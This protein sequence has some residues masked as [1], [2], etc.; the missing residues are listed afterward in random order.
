MHTLHS[1]PVVLA[2]GTRPEIIKMAPVALCLQRLGVPVRILHTGQHDEE[3]ALP[4][5][6]FFG[7][8]PAFVAQRLGRQER[9]RAYAADVTYLTAKEAGFDFL[10]DHTATE[11]G[12][13]VQ[14]AQG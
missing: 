12:D 3:M 11:P 2:M 13:L 6:R 10:R 1:A 9:R 8:T 4:L 5:Y 7:L 14:R